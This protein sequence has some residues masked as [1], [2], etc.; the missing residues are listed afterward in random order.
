[1]KVH[2][3]FSI[4]FIDGYSV[5]GLIESTSMSVEPL[6]CIIGILTK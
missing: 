3:S 6:Q 5:N 4:T 1:M 2:N